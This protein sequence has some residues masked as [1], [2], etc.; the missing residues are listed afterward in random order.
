M[1]TP[2]TTDLD[3]HG[4][5]V[6]TLNQPE[7]RNAWNPGLEQAFYAA[8]DAA[9]ADPRVRVAIVTGAGKTFCPGV[10][11]DRLDDV[12]RHGLDYTGRPPFSRTFGFRKPLIAAING[13]CAG[14]GLVQALMCDVR[15]ASETARLSTSFARRG[16]P[17]EHAL[18]WLLARLVGLERAMDLL[19][20]ARV[21]TAAEAK[22]LGLVSR[23]VAPDSLLPDAIAYAHDIA[24]NCAPNALALIKHQV[25]I[26][27]D[28]TY[29]DAL[30]RAYRVTVRTSVG[31]E[32]REGVTA[33]REQRPPAFTGLTADFSP[34]DIL[35]VPRP[36]LDVNPAATKASDAE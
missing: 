15:F 24:D 3:E 1:S 23:V 28:S 33:F 19:L 26:D 6:I 10:N 5:V 29:A 11:G 9:D 31:A 14:A 12:A 30:D 22:E 25:L 18:S 36:G 4:V 21:V 13:G 17:A 34:T 27:L 35:G 32:F 8:L 20:S 2:V 16:L 7:S